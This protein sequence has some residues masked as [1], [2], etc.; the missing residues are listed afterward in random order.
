[1]LNVSVHVVP[2]GAHEAVLWPDAQ[3]EAVAGFE[4]RGVLEGPGEVGGLLGD[5]F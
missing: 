4:R 2:G 1:M 3:L 5:V